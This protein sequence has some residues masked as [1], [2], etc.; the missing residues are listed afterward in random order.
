[1]WNGALV[2]EDLTVPVKVFAATEPRAVR[3]RELHG[4][5]GAPIEHRRVSAKSGR[6]LKADQVV[7]GFETSPGRFVVLTDEEIHAIEQPERRA[8]EIE[9][10]VPAQ[11]VDPARFDR[12][13]FLG[14]Q[15]EG[16]DAFAALVAALERTELAAIGRVV[17]RTKEQLVAVRA[18]D[19]VLRMSTLRFADELVA[20][21]DFEITAPKRA[22]TK[23]E[24]EM[25]EQ[26][27][28]GFAATFDP[29]TYPDAYYDRVD[30]YAKQKAKG[31]E[32]ELPAPDEPKPTDDLLDALKA[33]V[34]A[35]PKRRTKSRRPPA[36]RKAAR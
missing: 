34:E 16:R 7:K 18:G 12:A 1:M 10:I 13:Y 20:P 29:G 27:V 35:A 3:F 9:T 11:Q 36:K 31:Q 2:I 25:A 5:D 15:D 19:G 33:S 24:R 30:A 4:K 17:L 14:A 26:L 22:P 28:D 21:V 23:R 8:I 32:P 6:E